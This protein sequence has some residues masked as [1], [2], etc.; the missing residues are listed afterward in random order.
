MRSAA[1]CPAR[2]GLSGSRRLMGNQ[3]RACVEHGFGC[4]TMSMGGKLTRRIGLQRNEVCWG[5]Q[6]PDPNFL[7]FL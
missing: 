1:A 7:R 4:M 3:V 2:S 5:P 6:E